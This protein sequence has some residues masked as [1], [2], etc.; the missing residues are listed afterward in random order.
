V[1]DEGHT[2]TDQLK[3]AASLLKDTNVLGTV[4]NKA[5]DIKIGYTGV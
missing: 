4:F 1:I 2:K 3:H 5:T